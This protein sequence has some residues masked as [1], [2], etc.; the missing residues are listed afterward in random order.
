MS[1]D[2]QGF[3][4]RVQAV[5]SSATTER[6]ILPIAVYQE[7]SSHAYSQLKSL[8]FIML[9]LGS[10]YGENI[11][12][13]IHKIKE[14][15]SLILNDWGTSEEIVENVDA[16]L[17]EMEK[18][19]QSIN[20]GNMK[21]DLFEVLMYPLIKIMHPYASIELG[22]VLKEKKMMEHIVNMNMMLLF[23]IFKMKK[24]LFMNL[25]VETLI[26]KSH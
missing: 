17:S 5:R 13:I 22:K 2:V 4:R 19:G 20:L 23:V 16:T 25:K 21:G 12:P 10:I 11:Y 3:L 18:S 9:N 14:I 6:K 24:L 7:I 15:K 1:C 8:G 26:F